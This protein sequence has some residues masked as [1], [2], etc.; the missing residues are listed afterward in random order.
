LLKIKGGGGRKIKTTKLRRD[1][2]ES[3]TYD[4]DTTLRI[5]ENVGVVWE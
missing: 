1:Y 5:K 2:I 3:L 4:E